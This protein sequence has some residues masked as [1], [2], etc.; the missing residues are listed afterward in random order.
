MTTF[1][2]FFTQIF[3]FF[4]LLS[5]AQDDKNESP[6]FQIIGGND[7]ME[8]PLLSTNVEVK[9]N[10][11][12]A[13]VTLRQ[14]Y[15]NESDVAIEAIYIFPASS[16]SA[17]YEMEMHIG[18][19]VVK[20]EVQEK[21]K[22]RIT[23]EK[24]KAEG[25]R[26]SLLEQ[27]KPNVFQ[28]NVANI[29]PGEIVKVVMKYTEFIIPEDQHYS[30]HFP[31]VVGP[32]YTRESPAAFEAQPYSKAGEKPMYTFDI[33]VAIETSVPIA[34]IRCP[35]HK[36]ISNVL[37]SGLKVELDDDGYGGNKDFILELSLIHI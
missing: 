14:E 6:Y 37:G 22:T 17:V 27:H 16:R 21:R 28:M 26:A 30:F 20:A 2:L 24:A 19:R 15:K 1:K 25:K 4:S 31:T 32:R 9:I 29:M 7:K 11:P 5:I 34:A 35:S 33:N 10:G 3:I 12:I 23:Y 8:F 18:N 36:T 13:D